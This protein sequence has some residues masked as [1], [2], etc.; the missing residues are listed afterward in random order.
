[1]GDDG[2][3]GWT[4]FLNVFNPEGGYKYGTGWDT[5]TVTVLDKPVVDL[6]V[7]PGWSDNGNGP[8]DLG[9]TIEN[10]FYVGYPG[11]VPFAGETI[12]FSGNFDTG[13]PLDEGVSAIAFIKVF[14]PSYNLLDSV[15]ADVSEADGSFSLD[16][17]V[18]SEGVQDV[19]LGFSVIGTAGA[20]GSLRVSGLSLEISEP[21]V[22]G[23]MITGVLDGPLPGGLPLPGLTQTKPLTPVYGNGC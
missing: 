21:A 23:L 12:T 10:N 8:A 5:G 22:T 14:D 15:T 1:M 3:D 13:V 2:K 4:T 17:M 19:Q 18:P 16:V 7:H 20:E 9:D 6:M 11:S